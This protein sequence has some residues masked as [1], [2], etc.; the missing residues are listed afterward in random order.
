MRTGLVKRIECRDDLLSLLGVGMFLKAS[1]SAMYSG[2]RFSSK[3]LNF[4]ASSAAFFIVFLLNGL[5][6]R[7]ADNYHLAK[8]L[9]LGLIALNDADNL[10]CVRFQLGRVRLCTPAHTAALSK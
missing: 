7:L 8:S 5:I 2:P 9:V 1:T 6:D 10:L 3:S 4:W